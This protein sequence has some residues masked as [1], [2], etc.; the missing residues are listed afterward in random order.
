MNPLNPTVNLLEVH[1]LD[2]N[3]FL[4]KSLQPSNNALLS[5]AER[6]GGAQ[7]SGQVPPSPQG[8]GSRRARSLRNVQTQHGLNLAGSFILN[9]LRGWRLLSGAA[10]SS[11]EWR[12]IL[13]STKNQ[14]DYDSI[15]SALMVLFDEQIPHQHRLHHPG[16]GHHGGGP[17]HFNM[18]ENDDWSWD[19]SSWWD[20]QWAAQ[21]RWDDDGWDAHQP[22]EE[23][24]DE[25]EADTAPDGDALAAERSWSQAQ[26]TTQMIKKDRGFGSQTSSTKVLDAL[27]AVAIALLAIVL[28][29]THLVVAKAS[30][31]PF[32]WRSPTTRT[33]S[34]TKAR[35]NRKVVAR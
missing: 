25:A 29:A 18:A 11:E 26:R 3:E 12:S 19:D 24:G 1:D 34:C 31:F 30:V 9:Q 13:A 4:Q 35:A 22:E 14:L 5:E 28:I 23:H 16:A 27:S 2:I 33:M 15:S 7:P 8:G 10:L 6:P 17:H 32:S 21:V 20:D